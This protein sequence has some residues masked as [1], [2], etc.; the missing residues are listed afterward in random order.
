MSPQAGEGLVSAMGYFPSVESD[1]NAAFKAA[2][3]AEYGRD[4]PI[5][6]GAVDVWNAVHLWAAAANKAGSIEPDAVITALESGLTFDAPN[7]TVTLE[8]G[9]HHLRQDIYIAR[10]DANHGF[11]IVETFANAEPSYE[12]AQCNLIENPD[13]AEH[14]TP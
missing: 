1:T 3:E 11:E 12:N 9:S 6:A 8:P 4:T 2:W 5:V 10:G 14:F 7:G 13:L